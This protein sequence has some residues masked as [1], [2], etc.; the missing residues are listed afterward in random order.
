LIS[1]LEAVHFT[2]AFKGNSERHDK[3]LLV[4]MTVYPN[5][6]GMSDDESI[7]LLTV[8]Y[9]HRS[10]DSLLQVSQVPQIPVQWRGVSLELPCPIFS[11]GTE[12]VSRTCKG[13][14]HKLLAADHGSVR[15]VTNPAAQHFRQSHI[16]QNGF[17]VF[18]FQKL[19]SSSW[20]E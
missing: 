8:N 7:T 16:F 15:E 4:V 5:A 2:F 10:R 13:L 14:V 11:V 19:R 6:E 18:A 9:L 3:N 20:F 12:T 1:S 17:V